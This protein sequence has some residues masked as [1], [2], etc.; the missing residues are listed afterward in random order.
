MKESKIQCQFS[1]S[2]RLV[3]FE[4]HLGINSALVYRFGLFLTFICSSVILT[5]NMKDSEL[6]VDAGNTPRTR[7]HAIYTLTSIQLAFWME[8]KG[9]HRNAQLIYNEKY[10]HVVQY[11]GC[12]NLCRK[13]Q[14][15]DVLPVVETRYHKRFRTVQGL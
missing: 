9:L 13:I 15:M 10:W 14:G 4:P 12:C 8:M 6:I 3:H 1:F 11:A 2:F 7:I 5:A